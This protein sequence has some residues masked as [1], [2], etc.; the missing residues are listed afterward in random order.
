LKTKVKHFYVALGVGRHL[1]GW[2]IDENK[3]TEFDWWENKTFGDIT[4]TFT[5][6]RHFSGRGLTDSAKSLWGGWTFKTGKRIFG[7]AATEVMVK[8]FLEIGDNLDHL[9]L[10]SWNRG[11]YNELWHLIHMYPKKAFKLLLMLA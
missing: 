6:T 4:I 2:G 8:H 3:I 5:P 1:K 10:V 11:Q 9:I 7:L